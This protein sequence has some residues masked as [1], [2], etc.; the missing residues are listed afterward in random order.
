MGIFHCYVCLPEGRWW[1]QIFSIFTP[2]IGEM[3]RFDEHIFQ[4]GWFN[5]QPDSNGKWPMNEDVFPI[6]HGILQPAMLVYHDDPT[7]KV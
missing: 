2:K 6:D 7:T 4:M 3:I 5:H 1:F